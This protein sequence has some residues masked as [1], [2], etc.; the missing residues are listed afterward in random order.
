MKK[1][2]ND[3]IVPIGAK[4]TFST[5]QTDLIKRTICKGA[6]DDELKLFLYACKRTGLDPLARQAYAVKRWDAREQREVMSIQTSVD[7]FRLIA[8]RTGEYEGQ[9]ETLWCGPDG[10]WVDVWL[11][12]THPFAAKVGVHRKGFKEPLIAVARYDAYCQTKKD[13]TPTAMWVKMSDVM[14]AKC[15]ESLALR[16]A[17][18]QEMSG[19]YT[20]E[21]MGQADNAADAPIVDKQQE[22][23]R[24]P[25]RNVRHEPSQ[26]HIDLEK[27]LDAT[28]P[29]GGDPFAL[30]EKVTSYLD[31]NTV[32]PGVR[33][34]YLLTEDQAR[35]ALAKV[36][37]IAKQQNNGARNYQIE[38]GNKIS[39]YA[40]AHPQPD[41]DEQ[42]YKYL[43][44]E[45]CVGI[46]NLRK[47]DPKKLWQVVTPELAKKGLEKFE[48]E[49]QS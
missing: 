1:E 41:Q 18:P 12:K 20:G 44:M 19:L 37:N 25:A 3:E 42:T 29:Q 32:V 33:D 13:G 15:A 45:D 2:T 10:Q 34:A 28:T 39:A 47:L 22:Y 16:K 6:T 11:A 36:Q 17:F 21:E 31:G 24:P 9:T 26:A 7:G 8:E 14:L 23:H 49:Y 5:E 46:T 48:K 4:I 38:L 43:I 40:K 27:A 30:L 35:V